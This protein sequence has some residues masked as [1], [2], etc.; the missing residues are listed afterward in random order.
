MPI[1]SVQTLM[2]DATKR[3]YA[4][5]YFE[6]WNLASIQGVID[7]AETTASPVIIGF[8]GS[9]LSRPDRNAKERIAIYAAMAK[10]AAASSTVPCGVLFNECPQDDCIRQA[11]DAGFNFVMPADP[12]AP[13]EQYVRRVAELVDYAHQRGT[14]VEAEIGELPCGETGN[15][16]EGGSLTDPDEAAKFVQ[17][18]GIDMLAVSV[19]NVHVLVKGQQDL[20]LDRLAAIKEKVNVP[21]DLHGGTGITT[22]SLQKAIPLG[23]AKVAFGTY[24]KQR[25][26]EATRKALATEEINP[27]KLLGFGGEEDIMVIGR[28]AVRDA[29]LERIEMLG[30]CGKA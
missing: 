13:Y 1:E 7:A 10:A 8:N 16:E 18:T 3:G 25:Y 2:S 5:G 30:C 28:H 27:H 6:S 12:D 29:V 23:V 14:A 22:P 17:D 20:D 11:V 9:F 15:I 21:F 4:L 26:L 24:L 19:G